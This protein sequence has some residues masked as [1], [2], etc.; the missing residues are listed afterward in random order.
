M[1]CAYVAY[2]SLRLMN[3]ANNSRVGVPGWSRSGR[4]EKRMH[5]LAFSRA[6]DRR[7]IHMYITRMLAKQWADNRNAHM[8]DRPTATVRNRFRRNDACNARACIAHEGGGKLLNGF[9]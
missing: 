5:G 2:N 6:G 7:V 9:N 8:F 3:E 1:R 4:K